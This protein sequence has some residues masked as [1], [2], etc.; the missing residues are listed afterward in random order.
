MSVVAH[1]DVTKRPS[2]RRNSL[3]I[4]FQV[5]GPVQTGS[6]VPIRAVVETIGADPDVVQ[7]IAPGGSRA[8]SMRQ[9]A[10]AGLTGSGDHGTRPFVQLELWRQRRLHPWQVIRVASTRHSNGPMPRH[11]LVADPLR[12][13]HKLT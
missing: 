10:V 1:A 8:G 13:H 2:E 5:R 11:I 9:T 6:L 12:R 4:A 7:R 3:V